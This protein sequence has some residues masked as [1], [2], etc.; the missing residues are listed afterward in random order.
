M[1]D[2]PWWTWWNK[3]QQRWSARLG[4]WVI[5]GRGPYDGLYWDETGAEITFPA[6]LDLHWFKREVAPGIVRCP[7]IACMASQP[8]R[9]PRPRSA[10]D[11]ARY[12]ARR[13][14]EGLTYREIAEE[15]GVTRERVRQLVIAREL[16]WR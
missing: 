3:G 9:Y 12:A 5:A 4:R 11:R 2:E 8:R 13:R 7:V 6:L 15:M 10:S 1:I 16:V 14:D